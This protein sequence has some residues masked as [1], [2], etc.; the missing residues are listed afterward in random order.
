MNLAQ[1]ELEIPGMIEFSNL[2][3][4]EHTVVYIPYYMPTSNKKFSWP[5]EKLLTE[6][7]I[8]M[9]AIQPAILESDI[10]ERRV[11]GTA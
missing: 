2:R 4:M 10:L 11:T 7:F 6:A 1:P 3:Q 8:A 5:D 9:Q